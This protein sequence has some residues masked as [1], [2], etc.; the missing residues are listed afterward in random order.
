MQH[1]WCEM[2]TN[3]KMGFSIPVDGSG[4]DGV[5]TIVICLIS[6]C[7]YIL[8]ACFLLSPSSYILK[9]QVINLH[10]LSSHNEDETTI[11]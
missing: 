2:A 11:S 6:T 4:H 3:G 9:V 1:M 8:I 10:S 7:Q 5:V